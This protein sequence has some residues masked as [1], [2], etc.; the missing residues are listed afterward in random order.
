MTAGMVAYSSDSDLAG[1]EPFAILKPGKPPDTREVVRFFVLL[2]SCLQRQ[3]ARRNTLLCCVLSKGGGIFVAHEQPHPLLF[4]Y[5][6]A[7]ITAKITE[8][9][10]LTRSQTRHPMGPSCP[11]RRQPPGGRA[12]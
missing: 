6:A 2:A 10:M 11:P 1:I 12:S 9:C 7:K 3:S 4:T 8:T 5:A